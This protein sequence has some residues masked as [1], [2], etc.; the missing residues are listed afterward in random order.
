MYISRQLLHCCR[1]RVCFVVCACCGSDLSV[2]LD[3]INNNDPAFVDMLSGWATLFMMR[4]SV[5]PDSSGSISWSFLSQL[6]YVHPAWCLFMSTLYSCHS[7]YN[8][9]VDKPKHKLCHQMCWTVCSACMQ[10]RTRALGSP[11]VNEK[12]I[13]CVFGEI[14]HLYL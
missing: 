10:I 13:I 11:G 4:S 1:T 5:N 14:H 3:I 2:G 12:I 8:I 9:Y 6:L 7:M